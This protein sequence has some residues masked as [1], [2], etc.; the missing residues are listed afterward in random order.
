M[1]AVIPEVETIK[2]V[3][4]IHNVVD[5]LTTRKVSSLP[6]SETELLQQ[7]NQGLPEDI[8]HRYSQLKAKLNGETITP[9]EYQELL[10]LVD[11]VEQADAERL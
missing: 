1:W 8:Q 6:Q 10:T 3:Q 11:I 7:I 4:R 2:I 9:K 5:A